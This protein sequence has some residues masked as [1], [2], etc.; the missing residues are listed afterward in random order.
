MGPF[1]R[2]NLHRL[3][4]LP[5]G[6]E[7]F[8]PKGFPEHPA[9]EAKRGKGGGDPLSSPPIETG[10][11]W[12]GA[13]PYLPRTGHELL[14]GR[15]PR[16]R[17]RRR[18]PPVSRELQPPGPSRLWITLYQESLAQAVSAQ[19]REG[20]LSPSRSLL[21]PGRERKERKK[22]KATVFFPFSSLLAVR[23]C[24]SPPLPAPSGRKSSS[25]ALV[26]GA[27]AAALLLHRSYFAEPRK[28]EL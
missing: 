16:A 28:E 4:S 25:P 26:A 13:S 9:G 21:L 24:S 8:E 17:R 19:S 1:P 7:L 14:P 5:T 11:L 20:N 23:R 15:Q 2:Y 12:H 6:G 10:R 22:G 27:I 3:P 18:S